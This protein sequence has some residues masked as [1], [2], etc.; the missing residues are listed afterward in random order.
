MRPIVIAFL[1]LSFATPTLATDYNDPLFELQYGEHR[2]AISALHDITRGENV[3]VGIIDS[4]IDEHH[5][6]LHGQIHKVHNLVAATSPE[7]K[8]HG[9]A[10]A[11]I[12]AAAADNSSSR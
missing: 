11:G 3:R 1:I 6:D 2:S 10:V 8:H 7:A 9:T 4:H 5:P 12:I